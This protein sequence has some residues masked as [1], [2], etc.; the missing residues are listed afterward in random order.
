MDLTL[1]LSLAAWAVI[2]VILLI[3]GYYGVKFGIPSKPRGWSRIA[4][5]IIIILVILSYAGVFA[6]LAPE[7]ETV[8]KAAFEVS[9]TPDSTQTHVSYSEAQKKF[10]MAVQFNDTTPAFLSDTQYLEANFT[11][12]R[13]DVLL[14][15]AIA[16]GSLQKVETIPISGSPS[17]AILDEVADG[18]YA[19]MWTKASGVS[20]Y[21]DV[22]LLVEP[23]ESASVT[24]NV[25]LNAAAV[26]EMSL[27]GSATITFTLAGHTYTIE[28]I[29]TSESG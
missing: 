28:V 8:E 20:T 13:V 5:W 16:T 1:G 24:L 21:E 25:T 18:S 12:Y 14:T 6:V 23:G 17:E 10:T 4:G 2:G 9:V 22:S 11:V 27:Y 19:F 7:A 26:E 3:I 29:K 15:N